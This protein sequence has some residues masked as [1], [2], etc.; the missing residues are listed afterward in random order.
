MITVWHLVWFF[1][2]V[3][4]TPGDLADPPILILHRG[5]RTKVVGLRWPPKAQQQ[6]GV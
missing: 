3:C 4:S 5:L 2:A 1:S 6:P